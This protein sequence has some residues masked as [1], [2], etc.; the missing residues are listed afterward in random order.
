MHSDREGL[1]RA[2]ARGWLS[3]LVERCIWQHGKAK[4]T[5]R[6]GQVFVLKRLFQFPCRSNHRPCS[7]SSQ[8]SF[9]TVSLIHRSFLVWCGL[10]LFLSVSLSF[11]IF[12][13]GFGDWRERRRKRAHL[14]RKSWLD[15][16]TAWLLVIGK[17]WLT[18]D[19]FAPAHKP[20]HALG[21]HPS[22]CASVV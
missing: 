16:D 12:I 15:M 20:N 8:N 5:Q 17:E 14:G 22:R 7:L 2:W 13:T 11:I 4:S 6:E 9:P 19:W 18:G 1:R 21:I 10:T 3:T